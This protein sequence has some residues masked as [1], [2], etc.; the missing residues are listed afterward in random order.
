MSLANMQGKLSRA[1]MKKIMAGS[2]GDGDCPI[3]CQTA[4][5]CKQVNRGDTCSTCTDSHGTFN[6]CYWS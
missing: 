2:T 3:S 5:D 1:E 4:A 6:A